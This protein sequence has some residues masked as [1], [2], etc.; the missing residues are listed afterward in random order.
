MD[1]IAVMYLGQSLC[2]TPVWPIHTFPA[3][4]LAKVAPAWA[5]QEVYKDLEYG[6]Q[7]AADSPIAHKARTLWA[8][9]D[10]G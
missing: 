5:G 8:I 10:F 4:F 6:C 1:Y 2:K 9:P 7:D 3:A